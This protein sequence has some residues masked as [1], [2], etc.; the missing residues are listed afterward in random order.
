MEFFTRGSHQGSVFPMALTIRKSLRHS[1]IAS[2][3]EEL[4]EESRCP[5]HR[6][7][8]GAE[9]RVTVPRHRSPLGGSLPARLVAYVAG[10]LDRAENSSTVADLGHEPLGF[11]RK[12]SL[13]SGFW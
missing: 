2:W 12:Q 5:I 9:G 13:G 1:C 3:R 10:R 7:F 6:Q 11:A 4:L 8:I